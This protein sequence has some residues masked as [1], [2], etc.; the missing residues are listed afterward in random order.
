[1]INKYLSIKLKALS[2]FAIILVVFLHS[3]N[4]TF[5]MSSV[6]ISMTKGYNVIIQYF[7]SYGIT[8]IAVPLFF[9]MSGYL[10][11]NGLISG[12]IKEYTPKFKKRFKSLVLPYFI[13]SLLGLLFYF[14]LQS[15]PQSKPFFTK[16]LIK[17][18][19]IYDFF[20]ALFLNPIP[21]Q[22]WFIRDLIVLV[23]L[24]P[25]IYL[26]LSKI[27]YLLIVFFAVIWILDINFIFLT[28]ESLLFFSL[29]GF[30][31]IR[32]SN[33]QISNISKQRIFIWPLFWI[34]FTVLQTF[35]YFSNPDHEFIIRLFHKV[36]LSFGI[37]SI[38]IYYDALFKNYDIS[39]KKI[40][41]YFEY[42]IFIFLCHEPLLTILKKIF[43]YLLGATN[44]TSF[45]VFIITPIL[46]VLIC[47]LIAR[48]LKG[49][50]P[51]IYQITTGGR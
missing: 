44:N 49:T 39:Q 5:N 34:L 47:I 14:M 22:L 13:W 32:K 51:K 30:F 26:A 48:I 19:T 4:L 43:Y 17:D 18:F 10:F 1:M 7:I 50:I 29:G 46:T 12:K 8:R 36:G 20:N 27:K 45:V 9:M 31:N 38:W 3:Y 33:L 23:L 11:Y 40:Y 35:L 24:S 41:P 25:L 28:S 15:I 6:S 37:V 2:F 21:Y 42:T 16:I